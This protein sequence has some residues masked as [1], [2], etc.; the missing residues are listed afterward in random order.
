[1][2]RSYSEVLLETMLERRR[3]LRN[4]K[5]LAE[6]VARVVREAYPDARVYLTGSVARGEWTAASDVDILVALDHEPSPRE[7]ARVIE[8]IWEKLGLPPNHP[9]EVHVIGPQSLEKYR[10]RAPLQPLDTK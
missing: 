9:L 7:A 2:S 1:M 6:A 3:M 8:H 5:Q 4:W 10:R